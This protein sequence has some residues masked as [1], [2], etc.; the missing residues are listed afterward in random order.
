MKKNKKQISF[1]SCGRNTIKEKSPEFFSFVFERRMGLSPRQYIEKK[2]KNGSDV[3]ATKY[4]F[5]IMA[6][7]ISRQNNCQVFYFDYFYSIIRSN[8]SKPYNFTVTHITKPT[9]NTNTQ[10]TQSFFTE[11]TST[12]KLNERPENAGKLWTKEDD[13]LLIKMYNSTATK[14]E[15][16]N[17]FKRT[18]TGLA[19]RL[20]RLGVIKDRDV[21]RKRK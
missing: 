3:D 21:F 11:K 16:C 5:N 8:Q 17:V 1:T 6:S 9:V 15:M 18:E 4:L 20:V 14:K 7:E 10:K 19:A 13:Q 12:P 2:L